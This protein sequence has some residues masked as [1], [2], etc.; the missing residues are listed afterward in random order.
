MR[1]LLLIIFFPLQLAL[2]LLLSLTEPLRFLLNLFRRNRQ[3]TE[4]FCTTSCSLVML[5]WNGLHLL[6]ESIPAL[7]EAVRKT[8]GEHQVLVVDNGSTDGSQ[9]WLEENYPEVEV[10]EL[11]QN[12]GFGAGNNLGVKAASNEIVILLNNDMIVS[13]DFLEPL[14]RGFTG[15]DIFAVTSQVHF[16]DGKRREETGATAAWFDK[17]YL[18]FTHL[19][20]KKQHFARGY[21]P[22]LWAGGGSSAF[23]KS[24]FLELGGFSEIYSPCYQEDVDLSFRAWKRGW[25]SLVAADSNVLHK[26]RGTSNR[27]YSDKQLASMIEERK[28]WFIWINL[29]LKTLV[30]HLLLLPLSITRWIPIAAYFKAIRKLPKI[31]MSRMRMPPGV[32]SDREIMGWSEHPLLYLN[33][34]RAERFLEPRKSERLRILI[35]SAYLPHLGTHGGAGRVFQLM[36]RAAEKHE[37]TLITYLENEKDKQFL[38]QAE[39]CCHRVETVFR[40][41]YRHLSWYPYEPFE[42]F[43]CDSFRA[44]LEDLATE[45]DYDIVHFEWTQMAEFSDLFPYSPKIITEVEVNWA[46]HRTMVAVEP[47]LLKKIKKYYNTLQTLYREAELCAKADRVVCVTEDDKNYLLGYVATEKLMVI[48][49]GVDLDYF[50]FSEQGKDPNAIVFVGAFRHS[51]N[52]DAMFYFYRDIFP[53]IVEKCPSAHLYIVGSSPPD[54]IKE[55]G[56]Q[57]NITVTGFVEDIREYYR[58][59]QVVVVPIRTGVGIRG[60]VLEGWAAGSAMVASSLACQGLKAEHGNN[61]LIADNPAEFASHTIELLNNPCKCIELAR[62]GR[63]TVEAF[64]GWDAMGREMIEEYEAVNSSWKCPV[65]RKTT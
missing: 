40:G 32:Y 15:P 20:I 29:G 19:P 38:S 33:R 7:L 65:R 36:K 58:M 55:L 31:L 1:L 30:P 21:L 39:S 44:T 17:G 49:T 61:V 26:H 12:L 27:L 41:S 56:L 23:R 5:N 9:A 57:E 37:V 22:V 64:Y 45:S 51:P 43:N 50:S 16:P 52:Q 35:V 42:E 8:G 48:K 60:K 2:L 59:A 47:D 63:S 28:L 3:V 6:R 4:E 11:E 54:E 34:F 13:Y 25:H 62:S 18:H 24:M 10:L 53:K 14:L 46:A